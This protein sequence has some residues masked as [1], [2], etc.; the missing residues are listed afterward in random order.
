MD[1]N[2]T[3]KQKRHLRGLA[4]ELHPL[5]TISDKGLSEN[6]LAELE[7]TLEHHELI[8]VRVNAIDREQRRELIAQLVEKSCSTLIQT[9][10]HIALIYRAAKKPELKIP[11]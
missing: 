6:V 8:K 1:I 4:H 10:G 7:L 2:L 5:V 9:I 11:S 3:G